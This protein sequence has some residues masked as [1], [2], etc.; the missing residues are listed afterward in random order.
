MYILFLL[1]INVIYY[2]V[3]LKYAYPRKHISFK[4][5]KIGLL[6]SIYNS[7]SIYVDG[8]YFSLFPA[9]GIK[10]R[11]FTLTQDLAKLLAGFTRGMLLPRPLRV[12]V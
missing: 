2:Y 8:Q 11:V 4:S 5:L 10:P 12:P 6:S 9:L 7:K 1:Y 3:F